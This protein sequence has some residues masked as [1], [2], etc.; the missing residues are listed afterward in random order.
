VI[1]DK[2][3]A[4][5]SRRTL[6]QAAGALIVTFSLPSAGRAQTPRIGEDEPVLPGQVAAPGQSIPPGQID[7]WLAI[8]PDGGVTLYTGKVELGTGVSTA[9]AQIVAEELDVAVRRITVVQGDTA[10][11]PDQGVTAGSKT[12]QRGAGVIRQAAADARYTLRLLASVRLSTSVDQLATADGV[13]RVIDDPTRQATYGELVGG[14][15]FSRPVTRDF[16]TKPR[17][18]YT[19]VGTS[20]PRLD[21]P[22]KV[23]GAHVYVQDVRV[24]GMLH[25]RVVR[26]RAVGARVA[27]VDEASVGGL[28]GLVRVVH[29]GDFVGVVCEREEQ[30]IAAARALTVTW[31]GGSRLPAMASLHDVLTQIP[32]TPRVLVNRGDVDGVLKRAAAPLE[33]EY[34]WPYQ[35][36]ASIGPSCG[37]ADVRKDGATVWTSSQSVFELR[38]ALAGLLGLAAERVRAIFVEGSGCYGH[39]G[40]DDAAA[41][42]A[43]LSRAVGRPVRVQWMRHDEH[44]HEPKG[45]A[46][47]MRARGALDADRHVASWDYAVWTP[48]HTRRPA[49][50]AGNLLAGEETGALET[51]PRVGGGDRNAQHGYTFPSNRVV[52]HELDRS[53]LRVSALRGLGAPANIFAGESFVDELAAAA[54]AD[55]VEFRL[56][57]LADPRAVAVIRAAA[58]AG[59]WT[60]RPAAA[61]GA[62]AADPAVGRGIAYCQYENENAYVAGVVEVEVSRARGTIRVRRVAV[63]HD[64][65]LVVNP[66]GV[67]NQIEGNVLQ[68]ISRTLKEAV[69]FDAGGVTSL[70]WAS[71]PILTFAEAPDTVE[72][73]LVDPGDK[74]P[75]GAGEPAT[76][77]IPAAIANAVFDATGVRL[78]TVP[79]TPDRVR[80]EL[81]RA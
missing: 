75:V 35:M 62:R 31:R 39:N 23:T 2:P 28:S 61:S 16:Q 77:P 47:V 13:V 29:A 66:D 15:P 80:E 32:S 65:G 46:M 17:A 27:T 79:F 70:D 4:A 64:C 24:P 18:A 52:V 22:A 68:A 26:A 45:P 1:L 71:Y 30:A 10:R 5:L 6:L 78:R 3:G 19:V 21:V 81:A 56:R 11:T 57:H 25:G 40:A 60:P 12:I 20:V 67:R 72:I 7:A 50:R 51:V 69:Q 63:A 48:T 38:G 41:D 42:A 8:A 37:V 34:R 53:P 36:H 33:R 74:P 43:I 44:G 9:L 58:R 76:C 49:G 54:G 59:G 55:P 73:V 14:R